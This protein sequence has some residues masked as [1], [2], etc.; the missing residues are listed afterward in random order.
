MANIFQNL[1]DNYT[2][3][4]TKVGRAVSRAEH[5]EAVSASRTGV[6]LLPDYASATESDAA[7]QHVGTV[8]GGNYTI[9][10]NVPVEGIVYTTANLAW[11]ATGPTMQAALDTASPATVGDGDI[12]V[13]QGGS[14]GLSD[15][16]C[17]LLCSGNLVNTPILITVTDVDLT[18]GGTVGA[19]IRASAGRP[20]RNVAQALLELNIIDGTIPDCGEA[21]TDWTKPVDPDDYIGRTRRARLETIQW[22][23]TQLVVE[24][25]ITDNRNALQTLYN[26]PEALYGPHTS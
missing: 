23:A 25:G 12:F 2:F 16:N 24:E 18:G 9:S 17:A 8:S 14:A 3:P 22:L 7:L 13:G 5:L 6:N 26:L 21:N 20:D 10:V 1:L 19:V 11:N 4:A 15:G